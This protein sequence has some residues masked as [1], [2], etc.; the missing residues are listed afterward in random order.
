MAEAG[1]GLD[2]LTGLTGIEAAGTEAGLT[3]C[4][5]TIKTLA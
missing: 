4:V 5:V 3:D 2:A 1:C